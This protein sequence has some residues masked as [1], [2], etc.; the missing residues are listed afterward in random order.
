MRRLCFTKSILAALAI[1]AGCVL[2]A[3]SAAALPGAGMGKGAGNV[4]IVQ[5]AAHQRNHWQWQGGWWRHGPW[6]THG[7]HGAVV[8]RPRPSLVFFPWGAA[9]R[10]RYC[11][12]RYRNFDPATGTYVNRW[13][14]RRICR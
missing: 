3:G 6:A 8:A 5:P 10:L 14:K 13:G 12:A 11:A 7:L 9:E 2:A 1:A 4:E